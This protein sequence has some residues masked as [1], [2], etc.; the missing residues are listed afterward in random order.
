LNLDMHLT[1]WTDKSG[2]VFND[3]DDTDANS[4][5]EVDFLPHVQQRYF[6]HKQYRPMRP[7]S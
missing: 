1:F 6:L 3:A 4:L 2:H 5:A 7:A